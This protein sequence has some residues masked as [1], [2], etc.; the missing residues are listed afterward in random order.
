ML[1]N[2]N[3]TWEIIQEFQDKVCRV[4]APKSWIWQEVNPS[5]KWIKC[6]TCTSLKRSHLPCER[7]PGNE[8]ETR[9][10]ETC[11]QG[12]HEGFEIVNDQHVWQGWSRNS[13]IT[14]KIV[15]DNPDK[16]WN[17]Q[18]LSRNPNT[19][20]D[21]VMANQ[22]KPWDWDILS[23]NK[24]ITWDIIQSNPDNP[25]NFELISNNPNITCEII[26]QNIDK[27]WNGYYLSENPTISWDLVIKTPTIVWNAEKLSE[28][29]MTHDRDSWIHQRRLQHIKALQI[30]RH[31]R[32]CSCNP[33]YILARKLIYQVYES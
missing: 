12:C 28:N 32:N 23:L 29:T 5:L 24:N 4:E 11:S 8:P 1:D 7:K 21:I 19:T 3:L 20:W 9:V 6:S 22:D 18:E 13:N 14:W 15:F 17:W 25:W 2:P 30:Q 26:L 33:Q 10:K 16:P 31:W 27:P